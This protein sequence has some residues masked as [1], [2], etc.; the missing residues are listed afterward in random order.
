VAVAVV[1]RPLVGVREDGIGLRRLLE[2]L[3]RLGGAGVS[4]RMVLDRELPVGSLDLRRVR[5]AGDPQHL[6]IIP[7]VVAIV[8]QPFAPGAAVFAPAALPAL[9]SITSERVRD[10]DDRS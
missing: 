9:E 8:H 7:F 5:R 6:V 4:V 10:T 3:L 1:A 2:I